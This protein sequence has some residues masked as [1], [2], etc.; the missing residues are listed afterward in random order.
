MQTWTPEAGSDYPVT[1]IDARKSPMMS[2]RLHID[3]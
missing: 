1:T 3:V 2:L